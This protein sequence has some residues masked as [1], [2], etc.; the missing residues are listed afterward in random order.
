[1]LNK[2]TKQ[3]KIYL[4]G[5]IPIGN[6][7]GVDSLWRKKYINRLKEL[8]PKAVFL[9]PAYRDIDETD[10]KA[11]FGHDLFLIKQ[12]DLVLVNAEISVGLGTAQEM[13]IAKYFQKPIITVSPRGSY[14]SPVAT[15]ING[16]KVKKWHHPFLAAVSDWIIDDIKDIE[17]ILG[18]VF[19]KRKTPKWEVFVEEAIQ[20]YL[21]DYFPKDKK[22]LEM[23]EPQDGKRK[24][25]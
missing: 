5:R 17:S 23:I 18:G 25:S 3:I 21:K 11:I 16:K 7:P 14:Y 15:K 9:D 6:E 24:T 2:K 8:I 10:S 13:I 19:E 22:T 4:A 12:V 1:M 20:Y